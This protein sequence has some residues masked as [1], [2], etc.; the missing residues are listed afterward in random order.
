MSFSD[1]N[2]I[3]I[4]LEMTGLDPET[5]K[6]IEI[7]TKELPN[8]N[9]STGMTQQGRLLQERREVCLASNNGCAKLNEMS[10]FLHRPKV[11]TK[12]LSTQE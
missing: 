6:I 2:L 4:D 1:Q 9:I 3:W 8:T 7:A 11:T 5:H 10:L 12:L